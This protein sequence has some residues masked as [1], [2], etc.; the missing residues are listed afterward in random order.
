M[1][2]SYIRLLAKLLS[3][4]EGSLIYKVSLRDLYH[5]LR[6]LRNVEAYQLTIKFI[7]L[8]VLV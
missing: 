7:V 8:L 2:Y 4:L 5:Y 3:I 1:T 6:P